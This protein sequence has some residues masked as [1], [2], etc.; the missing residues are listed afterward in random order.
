MSRRE[1]WLRLLPRRLRHALVRRH[2]AFDPAVLEGVTL[3]VAHSAAAYRA[4]FGL[5]HDCYVERGW[6]TRQPSGM[7][8]TPQ[9]TLPHSTVFVMRR[10][11]EALGTVSVT[12]DSAAK[13]PIDL[14]Y[15]E[16]TQQLRGVCKQLAEIGALAVAKP[17]RH[18][19]LVMA[20]M[21][22]MWR[23]A[24]KELGITDILAAVDPRV[25]DYYAAL[26]SFRIFGP[27]R[28]YAGFGEAH[29]Q[30]DD[31]II[32]LHQNFDMA[33]EE[34]VWMWASAP[35]SRFTVYSLVNEAFPAPRECLPPSLDA[36]ALARYKLP[37][38]LLAELVRDTELRERL[39]TPTSHEL[40]R[41]RSRQTME[42]LQVQNLVG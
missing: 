1:G 7:W 10:G 3:E 12:Q 6:I 25:A 29:R 4:A 34:G 13:L 23:Y 41:K 20:L 26:F 28:N 40:L 15:P 27:V 31:P 21:A 14:T 37:R 9:H 8:L 39:D 22:T 16:Q 18:N 24:W 35:A 38:E 32:G 19:G 11:Q 5:V 42:L 33:L 17:A 2:A 36:L 30:E